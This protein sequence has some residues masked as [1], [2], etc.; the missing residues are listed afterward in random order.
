MP[1]PIVGI[2]HSMGGMQLAHLSLMHPSLFQALVL[3]EPVIQRG[4]PSKEFAL[5]STYRRD[6]WPSREEASQKFQSSSFYQNWDPRVLDKWVEY[7]LRDTPTELY[8][9]G[10]EDGQQQTVTLTTTKAQELFTFLR[11][12]YIDRRSGL[13]RGDPHREV[14]PA[15]IDDYPFYRPEPAQMFRRL[16]D[17]KPSVLYMF[18][19]SSVLSSPVARQEKMQTTGTGIGGSGGFSQ[20]RVKELVL[21][22]GHL[23]PMD[24][25][26]D[27]AAASTDFIHAELSSWESARKAQR[28]AWERIPRVER[29]SIDEQW[30]EHIGKLPKKRKG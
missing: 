2:A 11:P 6:L 10:D 9:Q 12:A 22:S 18:G 23:I 28:E 21:P 17:L 19:E 26:A 13:P 27:C 8:P 16:P 15:E 24:S 5:P 14:H 29:V 7:G 1:H 25:V 4:N 20:G 3:I 30:K